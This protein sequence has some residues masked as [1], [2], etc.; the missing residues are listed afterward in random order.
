LKPTGYHADARAEAD[1]ASVFYFR[2]NPEAASRF[3][4]ELERAVALIQASPQR[5]PFERGTSIQRYR[6]RKFPFTVFTRTIFTK[7][8]FSPSPMPAADPGIGNAASPANH[9][10]R[11]GPVLSKFRSFGQFR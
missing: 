9:F 6:L 4:D 3:L 1:A 2:D 11:R 7:S 10:R 5:W 8:L